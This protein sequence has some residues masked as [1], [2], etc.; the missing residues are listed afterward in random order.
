MD[1]LGNGIIQQVALTAHWDGEVEIG[2]TWWAGIGDSVRV[3][4]GYRRGV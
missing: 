1:S 4:A 3:G 2:H